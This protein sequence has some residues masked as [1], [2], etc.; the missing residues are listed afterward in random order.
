MSSSRKQAQTWPIPRHRYFEKQ[1]RESNTRWFQRHGFLVNNRMPYI[2]ESWEHWPR[3]MI[4]KEVAAF[5]QAEVD[6]RAAEN[7]GFPLHKYI[8]H[9]LSSQAI[10]FNLVGPMILQQD[11]GPL[12]GALRESGIEISN[13]NLKAQFEVEDRSIFNEDSGQPTSID[14]ALMSE[15]ADHS[16]YIE[17]KLV[18]R[19]FGGC[20]VFAN[21]DCSGRNP[22]SDLSICYLHH[23]GRR[24]W[25]L[26]EKHGFLVEKMR[27]SP[28]CPLSIYYQFFR[29][30]LFA[31]ESQGSFVLLYD[32]RNPVFFGIKQDEQNGLIPFLKEFIP[33]QLKD[34]F[35]TIT[36]QQVVDKLEEQGKVPWLNEFRSKYALINHETH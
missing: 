15:S 2:L 6:Q 14:L 5:I 25:T 16:I 19:A 4:L 17:A 10:L 1:L 28:I 36:I 21:G 33:L 9:G 3:N 31:I 23:L 7:R 26:L 27:T 22:A 34:S 20:S 29:E 30:L 8:H 11:L 12:L 24:Y 32:Q 13:P 18:E 35:H